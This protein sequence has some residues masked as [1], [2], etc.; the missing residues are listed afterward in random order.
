MRIL[1]FSTGAIALGDFRR[2][3]E[4]LSGHSLPAIELSALRTEELTPLVGALD[5][6]DL[7]GWKYIGFHAPSQYEKRDE[8]GIVE[9]LEER[10]PE[11][12]PIVVHPDAIHDFALWRRLGGRIAVENMDRRKRAGRSCE[13]MKSIFEQLPDAHFTFDIGHAR[14]FDTTMTEAYRLLRAFRDR[15]AWMHI[16]EVSSHTSRHERISFASQFAFRQVAALIP[17][18]VPV[19]IESRLDDRADADGIRAESEAAERSL[20]IQSN[21]EADFQDTDLST[22]SACRHPAKTRPTAAE[23]SF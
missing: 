23:I 15:L 19:I 13:E 12:W 21:E 5:T 3:L 10:V 16:S 1:G 20:P 9:M 11:G 2:A 22:S 6:L 17:K 7:S 8:A 18:K 4:L 14:Q